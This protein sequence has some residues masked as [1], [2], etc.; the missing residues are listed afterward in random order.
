MSVEDTKQVARRAFEALTAGDRGALQNLLA[1]EAVLH[2]CGF[3]DPL[4]AHSFLSGEFPRRG[5]LIDRQVRLQRMIGEGDLVA[6]HWLTT[7]RY[8]D[9]ESPE[10]DGK[11]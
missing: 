9:P 3:L 1:P 10:L 2:Q 8:R 7:G 6:L 11:A 4:P 5:P